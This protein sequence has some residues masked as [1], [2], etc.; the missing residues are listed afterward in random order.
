[1]SAES[2]TLSH[3]VDDFNKIVSK[4]ELL[5]NQITSIASGL[6]N[7]GSKSNYSCKIKKNRQGKYRR[8]RKK[9]LRL[10]CARQRVSSLDLLAN[11]DLQANS[12]SNTNT[13][14]S[15]ESISTFALHGFSNVFKSPNYSTLSTTG[16]FGVISS[17]AILSP[18]GLEWVRSKSMNSDIEIRYLTSWYTH[19]VKSRSTGK[20]LSIPSARKPLPDISI[21]EELMSIFKRSGLE[22]IAFISSNDVSCIFENLK[23]EGLSHLRPA[24]NLVVNVILALTCNV[25]LHCCSLADRHIS[26]PELR[27]EKALRDLEDLFISNSLYHYHRLCVVPEGI[28]SVQAMLALI[29]YT[30]FSGALQASFMIVSLA[31]RLAQDFGLHTELSYQGLKQDE[32]VRRRKLWW[33]CR[34]YDQKLAIILGRPPII[35]DY[36]TTTHFPRFNKCFELLY[37]VILGSSTEPKEYE[38]SFANSFFELVVKTAG[39]STFVGFYFS[40]LTRITSQIYT[41]LYAMPTTVN[42]SK[43]LSNAKDLLDDLK[44]FQLSLP[45]GMRPYD[46]FD[47]LSLPTFSDQNEVPPGMRM[48]LI[49]NIHFTYYVC[50]MLVQRAFFKIQAFMKGTGR[51]DIT[52]TCKSIHTAREVLKLAHEL[53]NLELEGLYRPFQWSITLAF[54]EIFV[55]SLSMQHD[56]L[57]FEN[58][59]KL[60]ARFYWKFKTRI[61]PSSPEENKYIYEP[62]C[63]DESQVLTTSFPFS[64]FKFMVNLLKNTFETRYSARVS[65]SE[66]VLECLKY[67]N[68]NED[69]SQSFE[70]QGNIL[71]SHNALSLS[72]Y[73][74]KFGSR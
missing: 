50:L 21:M 33:I 2:S 48:H 49:C 65:L 60:M 7:T 31:V 45:Q 8:K 58:D 47:A 20:P 27:S 73:E 19:F 56:Q 14:E 64:N 59:I 5:E 71:N 25:Q 37:D 4:L 29:A 32:V 57:E 63:Q 17:Y 46:N 30:D 55:Y 1:M 54:F 12:D 66:D 74:G 3:K 38:T 22:S 72:F 28:D 52:P 18:K 41:K 70:I 68:Q 11:V 40:R 42:L 10:A 9:N 62:Q 43:Q 24:Q 44:T 39:F 34:H 15:K 69:G 67:A 6:I 26:N 13:P 16:D 35:A 36:D 53:C 51:S 61:E 23:R